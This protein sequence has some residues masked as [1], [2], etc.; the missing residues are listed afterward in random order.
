M[1]QDPRSP[2]VTPF[3][4]SRY[5]I[6]TIIAI[7]V[8]VGVTSLVNK[9]NEGKAA[10]FDYKLELVTAYEFYNSPQADLNKQAILFASNG[11]IKFLPKC[12]CVQE[13][14]LDRFTVKGD[15]LV[16]HYDWETRHDTKYSYYH[17]IPSGD[18]QVA[19][20]LIAMLRDTVQRA[21]E[22]VMP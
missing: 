4:T 7:L 5:G 2:R 19:L 3:F 10:S 6:T 9:D 14:P 12:G 18:A 17:F 20:H 11:L 15:T 22:E 13:V 1:K 8:I 21:E 16:L